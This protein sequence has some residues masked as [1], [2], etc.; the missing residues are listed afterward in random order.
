MVQG[1]VMKYLGP[2]HGDL[3]KDLLLSRNSLQHAPADPVKVRK[4]S[5][6]TYSKL[7]T[8]HNYFF[9]IFNEDF[10]LVAF[11]H[12]EDWNDGVNY[13]MG[14]TATDARY[15]RTHT[16]HELI[17]DERI[18]A[19][20]AGVQFFEDLGR[21]ACWTT[22]RA[23]NPPVSLRSVPE[24]ALSKYSAEEVEI[25]PPF[26][27]FPWVHDRATRGPIDWRSHLIPAPLDYP[28][29]IVKMVKNDQTA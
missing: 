4:V 10:K 9:G 7:L 22:Y 12:F 6:Y 26:A 16:Y 3:I 8:Q 29:M 20:N 24:C 28:Q 14:I 25:H 5:A 1:L 17:S 13:N 21:T 2:E 27:H 23:D 11:S 18:A 19:V 15:P